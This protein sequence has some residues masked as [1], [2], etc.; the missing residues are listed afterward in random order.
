MDFARRARSGIASH[1][2]RMFRR[3]KLS[4]GRRWLPAGGVDGEKKLALRS[5]RRWGLASPSLGSI[6]QMR[7]SPLPLH[8]W[9]HR[10]RAKFRHPM[11]DGLTAQKARA[12]PFRKEIF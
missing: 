3:G 7:V 2:R 8:L 1:L 6:I 12:F 5:R 10:V 9:N 11:R 4:A